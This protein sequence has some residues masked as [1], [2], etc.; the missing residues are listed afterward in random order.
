M[1][2]VFMELACWNRK[3]KQDELPEDAQTQKS[4]AEEYLVL[5]T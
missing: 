4:S 1:L 5:H 2:N 3:Q